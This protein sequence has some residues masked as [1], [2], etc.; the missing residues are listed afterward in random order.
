ME[1]D[2]GIELKI[3]FLGNSGVGKTSMIN[4]YI[5][6]KFEKV[7]HPTLGPMYFSK[8][9]LVDGTTYKLR[10]RATKFLLFN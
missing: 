3:V 1:E 10:V 7:A 8:K 2:G 4:R 5:T 6:N 9:L